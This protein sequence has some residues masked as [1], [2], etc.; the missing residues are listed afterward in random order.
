M[1]LKSR[2]LKIGNQLGTSRAR[3]VACMPLGLH[4]LSIFRPVY[5]LAEPAFL[6]EPLLKAPSGQALE[7][8]PVRSFLASH[9]RFRR[10]GERRVLAEPPRE[11]AGAR[12]GRRNLGRMNSVIA[13][14]FSPPYIGTG[15]SPAIPNPPF[16]PISSSST[17]PD[18]ATW[19]ALPHPHGQRGLWRRRWLWWWILAA[20]GHLLP[21][22]R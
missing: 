2:R 3:L 19:P 13:L 12:A 21:P 9:P 17:L 22:R 6:R 11:M 10:T 8:R 16:P 5:Y 15:L 14:E 20:D 7:E 18:L 1:A 4:R